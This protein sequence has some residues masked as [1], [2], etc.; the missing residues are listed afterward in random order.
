[1]VKGQGMP[2]KKCDPN[3]RTSE[4]GVKAL[5]WGCFDCVT[6]ANNYFYDYGV[7]GVGDT[8]Q[9]CKTYDIDFVGGGNN[10]FEALHIFIPLII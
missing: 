10:L 2:I 8:I 7:E 6:L 3:L 1:M 9:T 4:K 5:K